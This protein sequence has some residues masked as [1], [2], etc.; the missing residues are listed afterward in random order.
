MRKIYLFLSMITLIGLYIFNPTVVKADED[1]DLGMDI[2]DI[3]IDAGTSEKIIRTYFSTLGTE[4]KYMLS[5]TFDI[6]EISYLDKQ[7]KAKAKTDE[8]RSIAKYDPETMYDK[9]LDLILFRRVIR[10]YHY[11]LSEHNGF[12]SIEGLFA[13][14][15]AP[16]TNATL[17]PG[18]TRL[19]FNIKFNNKCWEF[20]DALINTDPQSNPDCP[21]IIVK[22]NNQQTHIRYIDKKTQ[23]GFD[24]ICYNYIPWRFFNPGNLRDSKY[25]CTTLNTDPNGVFAIFPDEDTGWTALKWLL[26]SEDTTTKYPNLTARQAIKKY[27]PNNE[28]DTERY[29]QD[30]ANTGVDVDGKIL[31]DYTDEEME[32]LMQAIANVEGWYNG[33]KDTKCS[34]TY[35]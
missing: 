26:T 11:M 8:E 25:K 15:E 12:V 28:N 19:D 6:N 3:F 16:F 9:Y 21:Y 27:A 23:H 30:L 31:R 24:R 34:V 5:F 17:K 1:D 10:E 7:E 32:Q 22:Y 20:V 33:L 2:Y 14:C 13:V 18:Y 4:L 29:I 35:F